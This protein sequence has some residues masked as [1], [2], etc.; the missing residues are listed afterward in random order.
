MHHKHLLPLISLLV[1]LIPAI[2]CPWI[3]TPETEQETADAAD[4]AA[5][6]TQSASLQTVIAAQDT[7]DAQTEAA[8]ELTAFAPRR[9]TPTPSA[10]PT[11]TSSATSTTSSV[12]NGTATPT[13][14][15]TPGPSQAGAS[16]ANRYFPVVAGAAWTYGFTSLLGPSSRTSTITTLGNGAFTIQTQRTTPPSASISHWTCTP[17]G[18]AAGETNGIPLATIL[19]QTQPELSVDSYPVSGV[20]VPAELKPGDT[21]TQTVSGTI[22]SKSAPGAVTILYQFKA[23]GE[24]TVT[25]PAGTF[26]GMRV[27]GDAT[28]TLPDGASLPYKV[29]DWYAQGVGLVQA[30]TINNNN[31]LLWKLT[32][33]KIQ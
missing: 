12:V 6:H 30:E 32:S 28:A 18:L 17:D 23:V 31:T 25:V 10:T 29:A 4:A 26:Q 21:W 22:Q 11:P 19:E 16:C 33:Y 8:F 27:D 7:E 20:T 3:P 2:T 15:G 1:F 5:V 9:N 13:A 24:E 14:T